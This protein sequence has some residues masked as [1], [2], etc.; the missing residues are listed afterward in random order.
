MSQTF[1]LRGSVESLLEQ[2]PEL[3]SGATAAVE[4]SKTIKP[5]LLRYQAM[6]LFGLAQQFN[7]AG[8]NILELG[9]A[10]GY[11]ASMMAQGAPLARIVTLNPRQGEIE[12]A[13]KNLR[14]WPN[15]TVVVMYS[16][17]YLERTPAA[18]TPNETRLDMV[19]VDGDHNQIA[20][21]LPW[22]NRLSVGGLFLCH[23]YTPLGSKK[24]SPIVYAELN[25]MAE[26]LGR[27]FDVSLIDDGRVGMAG[28]YRHEGETA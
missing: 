18:Q 19:F 22:F 27:P 21:D 16:W 7:R 10:V 1:I 14:P 3:F 15:V 23:D 4:T 20:R 28:F 12:L 9:T 26:R 24:P 6:F 25:R 17:D 13:K 2:L 11:S 5:G 8:A